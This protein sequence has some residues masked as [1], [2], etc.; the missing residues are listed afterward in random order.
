M[1]N[2]FFKLE[3]YFEPLSGS[4]VFLVVNDKNGKANAM[5]IGWGT[6]GL[7]WYKPILTIL[8]RKSR[9]T[10]EL[11]EQN[12]NFTVSV[13]AQGEL[14]KALSVCGTK[15]GRDTDKIKESQLSVAKGKLDNTS[16]ITDCSLF[17]EC[18]I[19]HKNDVNPKSLGEGIKKDY[20]NNDDF[21]SIYFGEIIH[22]YNR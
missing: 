4:G 9:Y 10:Y 12:R 20:Y 16:I 8:V 6:V 21:H 17:Y 13:P 11:L 1:N 14:K 18:T 7:I 15:S 19:V 5:T 2:E 3:K 22:S